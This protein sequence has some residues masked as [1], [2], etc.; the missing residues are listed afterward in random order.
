METIHES[1]IYVV[2]LS[3]DE[4]ISSQA[5]DPRN[6]TSAISV[7]KDNVK[8]GKAKSFAAR[9]KNYHKT[10]GAHNVK[11]HPIILTDL[12]LIVLTLDGESSHIVLTVRID[13]LIEP[14]VGADSIENQSDCLSVQR[15]DTACL[16]V[17]AT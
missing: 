8:V 9:E 1:G 12:P 13:A 16:L 10:F 2:S 5:G 3:N 11:F 14:I 17:Q 7:N 6:E 4:P 15:S